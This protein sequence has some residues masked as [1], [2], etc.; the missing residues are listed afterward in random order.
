VGGRGV[1]SNTNIQT[2]T[3]FRKSE[4]GFELELPRREEEP[5]V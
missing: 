5:Q 1:G 2:I 3:E 4:F